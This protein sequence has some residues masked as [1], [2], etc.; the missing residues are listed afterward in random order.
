MA[1]ETLIPT[2][3]LDER[4]RRWDRVR[5]LMGE[6]QLDCL[7]GF[8]S[9]GRFEQF[10]ANTRYLIQIGG[11]MTEAAV[12][13]P[14]AGEVTAIVQTPRDVEWWSS[15]HHW[16]KD[17][18]AS[19]RTWGEP[20]INRL[21]ELHLERA[22]IGVIGLKGL[23]RAP[24]GI[25]P[26][27]MF[28]KVKETLPNAEFVNA[29]PLLLK[30]RAVKSS[31][32]ISFVERAEEVAERA[33]DTLAE[34]ARI[35]VRENIV[36]AAMINTMISHGAELPTMIYWSAGQ[37]RSVSHLVPTT[38]KLQ[39]GD[40]LTN[41]I[42]A[43]WGG[44]IAQVVAPAFVGP[45]P[46]H[47]QSTYA[48]SKKMFDVLCPRMRP[49]TALGSLSKEYQTM[50]KDAGYGPATWLFHGRGLGDDLP[51]MPAAM[52]DSEETLEEGN[53]LILKPGLEALDGG[54]EGT[55][56]AGETVVVTKDGAR[57]LGKRRM[58]VIEI[59]AS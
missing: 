18:R 42:E 44:Y 30:A 59:P 35:G 1:E 41:E 40:L 55:V 26:W 27:T 8:P 13:F 17:L 12:V 39:A 54:D 46:P 9:Q 6:G 45:I 51:I 23:V 57:R 29:T 53:V 37:G 10:H 56:R 21:K 28:E 14:L 4:K 34:V 7:I 36:Y 19:R 50:A 33:V 15:I 22:R 25:V 5:Q 2:F 11:F 38:R 3:S 58:A 20:I 31:E 16:I 43:K 32:E 52:V 49:G 24:E 47:H 48:T